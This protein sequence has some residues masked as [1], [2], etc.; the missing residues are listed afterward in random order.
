MSGN[1]MILPDRFSPKRF[2]REIADSGATIM[3]FMGIIPPLMLSLEPGPDEQRQ[4]CRLGFGPGVAPDVRTGF[5]ARFGIKL[6]DAWGMTE[7]ARAIRNNVEPRDFTPGAIGRPARGLEVRIVDDDDHHVPGGEP[8]ELV[9]RAA[10]DDPRDG[11]TS[12]YLKDPEATEQAWR[13][14]WFHTG[15]LV[16]QSPEG[17]FYFVDRKKNIIRR[18]GEN[19]SG[20]EVEAAL[21]THPAVGMA[22]VIA[23]ED[24]LRQEECM[25]CII[26][27]PHHGATAETAQAIF[28]HVT[29]RLAY[30]K[31][32]GWIIFMDELPVTQTQKIQKHRLFAPG[33][34]PRHLPGAIDLRASKVSR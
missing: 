5:E 20:A 27:N 26:L 25:A 2:W 30:F 33:V 6:I 9:L 19:I 1:C 8:G 21:L 11:F 14:G 12:G 23:V 17:A 28:R 24:E 13:G 7:V 34:D 16:R 18:S 3:A 15:D 22:A 31:A 10:G 4:V 29:E 32:P